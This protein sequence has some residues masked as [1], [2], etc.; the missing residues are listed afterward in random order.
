MLSFHL[1][2]ILYYNILGFGS[3]GDVFNY[4]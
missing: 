3:G 2:E 1:S 4:I